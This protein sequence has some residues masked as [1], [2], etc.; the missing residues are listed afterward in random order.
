M[1]EILSRP[2][3]LIIIAA[4]CVIGTGLA[5]VVFLHEPSEPDSQAQTEATRA[6]SSVPEETTAAKET[7]APSEAAGAE[8]TGFSVYIETGHGIEDNGNWDAGAVW[9]DGSQ[10]YEE[11]RLMIPIAKAMAKYLRLSGV[12]VYT[13]AD[14]DN[15]M[16]LAY[17]LDFLDSHPEIDA[18]VN[19]HCDWE[20]AGSGTMPLYRTEEQKALAEALNQGVHEYIDIPDRGL[21]YRDDLDTTTSE[22]AHCPAVIF[23]TG[24]ISADN[25]TLTT[26]YEDYGKGL[27]AGMCRYLGIPTGF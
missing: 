15:N 12:E 17:T 4:V 8:Q 24:S 20:E 27:A 7:T 13:D 26:Q 14:D 5:M 9:S 1:R 25:K 3:I 19:I 21:V 18:F 22:K 11:A 23:E 2:V 16:N 6:S 10:T